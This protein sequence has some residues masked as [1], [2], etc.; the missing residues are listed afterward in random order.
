[1]NLF[2][3]SNKN[4]LRLGVGLSRAETVT[5]YTWEKFAEMVFCQISI[6]FNPKQTKKSLSGR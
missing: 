2:M 5:E 4:P 6:H 1:M 3:S